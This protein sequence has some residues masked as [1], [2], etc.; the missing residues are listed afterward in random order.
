MTNTT[1]EILRWVVPLAILLGA[2]V[3][4]DWPLIREWAADRRF[5]RQMANY[6]HNHAEQLRN[7]AEFEVLAA[8]PEAPHPWDTKP[9][10]VRRVIC[11]PQVD[12]R[13]LWN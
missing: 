8:H 9:Y 5:Q 13:Q 4:V 3:V 1:I 2:W 6:E 11:P 12:D 7:Q 10:D